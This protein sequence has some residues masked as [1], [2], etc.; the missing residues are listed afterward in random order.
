MKRII[1]LFLILTMLLCFSAC[2]TTTIDGKEV[3]VLDG[4]F[5]VIEQQQ[6]NDYLVYDINTKVV[7]YLE[8]SSE[9]SQ[10]APYQIYQDGALYGA[11]YENGEIVPVS[12]AMG[13][14]EEMIENY[15]NGLFQ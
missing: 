8:S 12:Y 15:F 3:K 7:Y 10:L 14:T 9:C 1:C 6:G 4:Y 13:I 11:V 2:S 5:A